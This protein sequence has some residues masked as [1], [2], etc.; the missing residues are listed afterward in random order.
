MELNNPEVVLGILKLIVG[1]IA[2]F[3]AIL[4]WSRTRDGARTSLAA[5][6]VTSYAGLV[7]SLLLR[8][9]IDFA[10][11]LFFPKTDVPLLSVLFILVSGFFI[12]LAFILFLIKI[13]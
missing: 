11:T 13:K 2:A 5:G 10:P 3:L 6:A 8:L 9:G 7:H 1:G 12:I 4:L